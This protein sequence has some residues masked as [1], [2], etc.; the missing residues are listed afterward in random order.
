MI[1]FNHSKRIYIRELTATLAALN[2]LAILDRGYS[3]TRTIP[4]AA[5]VKDA[6][7][8]A[9]DQKLEV[10]LANGRLICRV[11]GKINHGKKDI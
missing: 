8:V 6:Q 1:I 7:T 10:T 5:V 2:P 4:K 3:I 11:K 9:L